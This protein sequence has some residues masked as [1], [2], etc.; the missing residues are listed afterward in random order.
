MPNV[1]PPEP[2]SYHHHEREGSNPE[3][4]TS[5]ALLPVL[6]DQLQRQGVLEDL[7]RKGLDVLRRV[8]ANLA[9]GAAVGRQGFDAESLKE[10]GF[11][12][13]RASSPRC[14][15]RNPDLLPKCWARP[16]A[17]QPARR[18]RAGGD[19]CRTDTQETET[20]TRRRPCC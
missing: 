6:L 1:E 17:P 2:I 14:S 13:N 20:L 18:A 15:T 9:Q 16:S 8:L 11:A 3:Y 19:E 7:G 12:K 10:S 4:T 5:G